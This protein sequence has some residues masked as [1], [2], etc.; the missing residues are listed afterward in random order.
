MEGKIKRERT[1]SGNSSSTKG[2]TIQALVAKHK[3]KAHKKTEKA[4]AEAA[5]SKLSDIEIELSR[6]AEANALANSQQAVDSARG[7]KT[8]DEHTQI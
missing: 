8:E 7:N 1:L 4:K 3:A 2:D 6:I 5:K